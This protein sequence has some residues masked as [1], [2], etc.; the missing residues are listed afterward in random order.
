MAWA[1]CPEFIS[2]KRAVPTA[3]VLSAIS[4]ATI[5]GIF[6]VDKLVLTFILG[7]G[8]GLYYVRER[9]LIPLMFGHFVADLWTYGLS[10]L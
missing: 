10:V 5:H 3:I 7:L 9:N 6:L 8:T 1:P 2:R 4:F